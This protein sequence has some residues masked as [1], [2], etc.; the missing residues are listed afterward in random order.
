MV[1]TAHLTTSEPH[2]RA[3]FHHLSALIRR[4]KVALSLTQLHFHHLFALGG[5]PCG[6]GRGVK[7]GNRGGGVPTYK[8]ETPLHTR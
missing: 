2:Q 5:A 7:G 8:A 3:H 4:R 6:G 1:E